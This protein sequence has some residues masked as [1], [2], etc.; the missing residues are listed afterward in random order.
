M[1]L[2]DPLF[3]SPPQVKQYHRLK[4]EASKRAATLAQELEK[5]NRDQK[6]DQ[7]RLDLEERKKVETEVNKIMMACLPVPEYIDFNWFDFTTTIYFICFS[8]GQNQTEDPWNWGKPETYW[9]IRRLHY[10][11]QVCSSHFCFEQLI[12]FIGLSII[13]VHSHSFVLLLLRQSLDEQKRME[14]E[15]TEEVEMAKRRIDEINVEL[16]Q[17]L[18]T[19]TQGKKSKWLQMVSP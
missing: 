4:E 1:T 7:D 12:D 19:H 17:V 13:L 14:E 5:F 16:N 2:H 10:H 18:N 3:L 6:A 11:Q 15:L 8:P 9:E